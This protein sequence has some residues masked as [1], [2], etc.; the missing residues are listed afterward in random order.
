MINGTEHQ[1]TRKLEGS[2][3]KLFKDIIISHS[4]QIP[5][6]QPYTYI[7]LTEILEWINAHQLRNKQDSIKYG[8]RIIQE[9]WKCKHSRKSNRTVTGFLRD[10]Q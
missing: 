4:L 10:D 3:H 9:I 6:H 7:A 8:I 5:L 2:G 1:M